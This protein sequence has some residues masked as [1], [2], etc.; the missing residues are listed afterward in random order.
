MKLNGVMQTLVAACLLCAHSASADSLF[1]EDQF[2]AMVADHRAYRIGD[3]LTVVITEIAS[4]TSTAKTTTAKEAALS[5][6]LRK[7]DESFDLAAGLGDEFSGGG[8]TER[9]GKLLA[10]ITVAVTSIEPGGDLSVKGNQEIEVNNEKQRI[11]VVGRVRPQDINADNTVLSARIRDAHIEFIGKGV[12]AEKQ[13][14]GIL[15]RFLSWLG[16]L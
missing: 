4:A 1:N 9:T 3:S 11:S 2:R 16:I 6:S 13:K 5:A 8:R 12:L 14:P 10:R 7:K 15:T